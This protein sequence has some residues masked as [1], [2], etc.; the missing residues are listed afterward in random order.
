M[1][2]RAHVRLPLMARFSQY[3]GFCAES[4]HG[5]PADHRSQQFRNFTPS[6]ALSLGGLG[7]PRLEHQEAVQLATFVTRR[8]RAY[9]DNF[10][11]G[12]SERHPCLGLEGDER[13]GEGP[14][15]P[16]PPDPPSEAMLEALQAQGEHDEGFSTP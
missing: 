12:R 15:Y 3:D 4:G 9:W 14:K 7:M 2:E 11:A 8:R 6:S 13:D 10:R 16:F 1:A 5:E